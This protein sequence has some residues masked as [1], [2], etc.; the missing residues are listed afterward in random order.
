VG[1]KSK[2]PLKQ[3]CVLAPTWFYAFIP[4]RFAGGLTVTL[5]PLY[6]VQ[7][8]E[9]SVA[10]VG[11]V[12]AL[13]A[14]AAVP[15]SVLWGNLSDRLA[16]RLPFILLGLVGFSVSLILMSLGRSVT[17]VLV[18]S[19]VG[20]LF[21]AAIEPAASAFLLDQLPEEEWATGLGRMNQI[22]GWSF[23]AGLVA[24]MMWMALLSGPW[25][26]QA[27][28][29][30]LLLVAGGVAA[31]SLFFAGAWLRE[32]ATVR[33]R[34]RFTPQYVGRLTTA[35][36][37][38]TLTYPIRVLYFVLRPT[39]LSEVRGY[40]RGALRRYFLFCLLLF[41]AINV[42]FVPFPI[43]LTDVLGATNAQV[44]LISLLKS[45]TDAIL[46][47]PMGRIVQ[48]RHGVGLLAQAAA[49]RVAIFAVLGLLAWI[50]PGPAVLLPLAVI[51]VFTGVTWAAIAVSGT[52]AV[53]RLAPKGLE[54]RCLGL[55]NAVIGTAGIFGSLVA[56]FMAENLGYAASFG[57]AALLIGLATAW[58]WQ[59][60]SSVLSASQRTQHLQ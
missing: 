11:L 8:V 27:A 20:A 7:V 32:P 55:Y 26:T 25:G 9:G 10:A 47:V 50:E 53:A 21:T 33:L 43:F 12:T 37:E 48:R 15:S 19:T 2:F 23:V 16:R 49:G 5:V 3:W 28:M 59:L 42:G 45:T 41:F 1:I 4:Y 52:T 31:L 13:A 34:R 44:F 18:I 22:G 6:V 54:G 39:F 51:H 35:V 30:R 38:R 46:Y 57:A 40:L 56:G 24:G 36:V 29:R 17:Q 58:L 14:L 60:R